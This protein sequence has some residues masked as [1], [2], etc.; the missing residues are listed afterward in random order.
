VEYQDTLKDNA[1]FTR[2]QTVTPEELIGNCCLGKVV[3]GGGGVIVWRATHLED[4]AGSAPSTS[5]A[6]D[7]STLTV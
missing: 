1:K 3:V 6:V 2:L 7:S 5:P 4:V